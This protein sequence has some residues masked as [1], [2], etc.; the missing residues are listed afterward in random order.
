MPVMPDA[1][2]FAT[3]SYDQA[4]A[5]ARDRAFRALGPIHLA[6]RSNEKPRPRWP[7]DRVHNTPRNLGGTGDVLEENLSRQNRVARWNTRGFKIIGEQT[8][9][10]TNCI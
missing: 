8:G 3:R 2:L 7:T 10:G 5:T 1:A 9:D 4:H 6:T